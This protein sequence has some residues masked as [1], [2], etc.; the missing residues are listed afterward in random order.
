MDKIKML[1]VAMFLP[2]LQ[3]LLLLASISPVTSRLNS[4]QVTSYRTLRKTKNGEAMC[5]MDTANETISSSSQQQCSL[6][7]ARMLP[8][9]A[10]AIP[11]LASTSRTNSPV[12]CTIINRSSAYWSQAARS[13]RYTGNIS[14][15]RKLIRSSATAEKQRVSCAHYLSRLANYN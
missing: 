3:L 7:C 14:K 4:I 11:V 5:A 8:V 1:L 15:I 13:I 10:D 9:L 6:R 2:L 12:I